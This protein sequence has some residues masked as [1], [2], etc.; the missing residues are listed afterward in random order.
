MVD[1]GSTN[2]KIDHTGFSPHAAIYSTRPDVKCVIHIHTLATAAVSQPC[3]K[4]R[5]TTERADAMLVPT[6]CFV[7][8]LLPHP[9]NPSA[10]PESKKFLE[11]NASTLGNT[12][13]NKCGFKN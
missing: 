9:A 2:L 13:R 12:C 5:M 4:A 6:W 10:F 7:V 3:A 11:P 1:Q 8:C